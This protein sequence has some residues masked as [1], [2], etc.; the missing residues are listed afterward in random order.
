MNAEVPY[1]LLVV[2]GGINGAGI[3][4]DAA[5]R[6]LSVCL[7]EQ[8]DLATGTSQASSKLIH[9]GLRYLEMYEFRLVREALAEREVLLKAAPHIIWPLRFVLP[10]NR[11]LRPAWLIRLGL[12]LY[13]R[14]GGRR[15]LPGTRSLDLRREAQGAPLKPELVRGFEYS[16]CWVEDSRLVVLNARDA[17][18]RGADIRVRT[19]CAAARRDGDHWRATL[20]DTE[21]GA[22]HEVAAKVLV[23]AAGPWVDRFLRQGLGRNHATH[24]RL[25]KGS[26][27]IVPRLYD[28]AHAYILQN[29]DKRV[30]FLIPYERDYTLIGTT[31]SVF[32]GDPA[33][34][35]ISGEETRYL[36]DAVNRY[37]DRPVAEA[38]IVRTYAGVRPLFDDGRVEASAVTRDYVFDIE[39]PDGQAALLSVYGGKITTYRRLA[40]HALERLTAYLPAQRPAWTATRPLPGG[41]LPDAD[42]DAFVSTLRRDHPGLPERLIR[43]LARLYGTCARKVLKDAGT[44]PDLGV[45]FGAD[46]TEAEVRYLMDEEWARTADDIV[47]RRTKLGLRMTADEIAGLGRWMQG[48]RAGRRDAA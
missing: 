45:R 17:A 39:A 5:G 14:L 6:G 33:E 38:D 44:V 30:I 40:E 4:R 29:T 23:N 19:R 9:G 8:D 16:D 21:T 37:L 7:V 24:L 22:R 11:L 48:Q 3:A 12:F 42:F 32:D 34:V 2:G 13:D 1:D 31:D 10:H 20:E 28:G 46:L 41:D 15:S 27:L 25:V 26:H 47:W 43:R 18:D 36:L 35:R